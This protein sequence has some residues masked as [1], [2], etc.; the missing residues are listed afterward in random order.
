[1]KKQ[2][3]YYGKRLIGYVIGVM[4]FYA[5]FDGFARLADLLRRHRCTAFMS[6]VSVSL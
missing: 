3:K 5:P 1:M 2:C 6:R 4:L